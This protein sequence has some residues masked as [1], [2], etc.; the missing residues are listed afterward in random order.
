M[1]IITNP[2]K[3]LRVTA[4]GIVDDTSTDTATAIDTATANCN[5][6]FYEEILIFQ[7]SNFEILIQGLD[8]L[9]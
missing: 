2:F 7:T 8:A 9:S 5:L 3:T 4:T 1:I 6:G